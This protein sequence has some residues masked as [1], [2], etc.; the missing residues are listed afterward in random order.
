M[1]QRSPDRSAKLTR[2][3]GS[4]RDWNSGDASPVDALTSAPPSGWP[5]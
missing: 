4:V 3:D 2:P 1:R 5:R